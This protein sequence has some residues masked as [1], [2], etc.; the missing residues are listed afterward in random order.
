MLVKVYFSE[1][2]VKLIV[3]L[4]FLWLVLAQKQTNKQHSGNRNALLFSLF[5]FKHTYV[6]P[7][8]ISSW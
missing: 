3:M 5:F 7:S 2:N 4:L 8:G 1:I 6:E